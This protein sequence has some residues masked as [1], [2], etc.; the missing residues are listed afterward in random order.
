MMARSIDS[1]D[2]IREKA[3]SFPE[4]AKGTKAVKKK[5]ATKVAKKKGNH[6]HTQPGIS[7]PDLLFFLVGVTV[8]QLF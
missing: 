4:V 1:T 7:T 8:D 3:A 2:P 5:S 6:R